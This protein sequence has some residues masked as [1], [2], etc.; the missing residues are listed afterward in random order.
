MRLEKI[1]RILKEDNLLI[2]S[3]FVN[4]I[5]EFNN[6]ETDSRKVKQNDIFVCITGFE[7]D[8]HKFAK[9]AVQNG[10]KLLIVEKK[11]AIEENQIIVKSSR[12]AAALIAKI[13]FDNPTS[14]FKLIGITGTNG[15]TTTSQIIYKILIN[16]EIKCGS[17]GTLGYFI[18]EKKHKLER[19][20]PD[21]IQLNQIFAEMA[22]SN[23]EI[24][25]MEVS[26]HAI[27]LDRIYGLE[28]D[29]VNFTNLTQD[30]LDFHKDINEY[31][32]TKLRLFQEFKFDKAF[33]NSDDKYGK[34]ISQNIDNVSTFGFEKSEYQID[35]YKS[36]VEKTQ[37]S[38]SNI[39]KFDSKLIGKFNSYNITMAILNIIELRSEL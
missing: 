25:I 32:H 14:K 10:A 1:L 19:T 29:I 36:N 8:G 3:V 39:G 9:K 35:N 26:S 27:A 11:L 31:F 30:H 13:R 20:T 17:I 12:K 6:V 34:I 22:Q 16:N 2:D 28:F 38:I 33:I 5:A 4:G 24:V 23:L 7:T 21:I 15:K 18:N 37:F